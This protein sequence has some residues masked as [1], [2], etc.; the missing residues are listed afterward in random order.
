[1]K[2]GQV[3]SLVV[4]TWLGLCTAG[5]TAPPEAKDDTDRQFHYVVPYIRRHDLPVNLGPTGA[6]GYVCRDLLLVKGTHPNTSARGLLREWDILTGVAGAA[7]GQEDDPRVAVGRA[8]T[9]AEA[10]SGV[11]ELEVLR[12]GAKQR[13]RVP[14]RVLGPYSATWPFECKKSQAIL[15]EACRFVAER[16]RPDAGTTGHRE[17]NALLLL[18]SGDLGYL[19][20]IRRTAYRV[21]EDPLISGYQGWSRSFAGMLLGEYCLA[22]GDPTA[23]PK[24]QALAKATAAG[25]MLCGSWGH[26]MPWD[27][28]GAVNQIGLMCFISLALFQEAGVAVD[29][30]AMRRSSEFFVKFAGKGWVPYG[31]HCPWRGNSGNGKNGSAAVAFDL[32][33]TY[34]KAVADF[35]ETVA[36]SYKCR[37]EGHT[38]AF[39]SFLWGPPGAIRAPKAMFRT[40]ADEQTWYYDL[41]RTADS[42]IVCQPNPENLSGRTPGT[43][44]QWGPQWTTGGM[45]LLYALP[46]RG[47]R[48]LGGEKGVFSKRPPASLREAQ[49]LWNAK[50][51]RECAAF[52]QA[53]LKKPGLSAAETAWAKGLLAAYERMEQGVAATE[54]AIAENIAKGDLFL[55]SE[56]LAAL[57]RLLGEER[58]KMAELAK[59]LDAEAVAAQAEVAK[60]YYQALG[61]YAR[62]PNEWRRMQS[63]AKSGKG[64]YA[65]LAAKALAAADPPAE[66]PKLEWETL[67]A[68]SE[69]APPP[70]K[71]PARE[72]DAGSLE[73]EVGWRHLQWD[74]PADDAP[75]AKALMGWYLPGFDASGWKAGKE[76]FSPGRG[77]GTIWDKA[78]IVLRRTFRLKDTSY[79]QLSL[80]MDCPPETQVYLNGFRVL[81]VASTPNA[82]YTPVVLRDK[83]VE[84]LK[85]GENVIA[86]CA[87]KGRGN[88]LDVGLRAAR[89]KSR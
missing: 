21:L 84:L 33:G 15:A 28:Y 1:V 29:P 18:A 36:A 75:L 60:E 14:L 82:T 59:A 71:E 48:M 62:R 50:K 58:P 17:F 53:F 49:A 37:E 23:L 30:E 25:Q 52:L 34:P 80:V 7:F 87:T 39:F 3:F 10:G 78:N 65:A 43:Y 66:E 40:F 9:Q 51:W 35:A 74:A 47:L 63:L 56:Q 85:K 88:T 20:V 77:K 73:L 54:K 83:A 38:G 26:R 44:T 41:A 2:G 55:A 81:D 12:D 68:S 42:G 13:V 5:H 64:H 19:D 61:G 70:P 6:W 4:S 57:K 79:A 46:G 16:S 31:D 45:A 11:L 67:V 86:V 32:L 22:T 76:P 8:V 27:G 72:P 89:V 24:L 69:G